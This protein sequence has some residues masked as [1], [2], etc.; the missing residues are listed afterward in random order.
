MRLRK[1]IK[2]ARE[3]KNGKMA[4]HFG[5]YGV[6]LLS[7]APLWNGVLRRRSFSGRSIRA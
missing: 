6:V 4:H 5:S 1:G 7:D 2:S 3:D